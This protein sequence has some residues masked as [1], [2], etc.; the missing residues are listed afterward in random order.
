MVNAQNADYSSNLTWKDFAQ[1]KIA[2]KSTKKVA[3]SALMDI[4]STRMVAVLCMTLTALQEISMKNVSDA[5][6]DSMSILNQDVAQL[7]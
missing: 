3:Q 6:K 4:K 7:F 5:T 1:S 2:S